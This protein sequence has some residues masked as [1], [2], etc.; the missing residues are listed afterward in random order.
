MIMSLRSFR[1]RLSRPRLPRTPQ[2]LTDS[3][4]LSQ[5]W[6]YTVELMPGL[7]AQ[8][9]YPDSFPL[10]PRSL[11]RNCDLRG[12]ECLDLGSMEGLMP[13]LMG[14]Q[15]ARRVVATDAVDHCHDKM[16]AVRHYYDADFSFEKVGLMYDLVRK[17]GGTGGTGFDLINCSGLLY[18]V[19]S[20]LMVLAG[21]RPLLRKNGLLI[22][23]TN[24]VADQSV[25]MHFNEGGRLQEETNTFWYLSI[26]ALDYLLRYL[27]LAPIDCVYLPHREI[28]SSVRYV[29]ALESGY[30]SIVCRARDDVLAAAGDEWMGK[31]ARESWEYTGLID[32][33]MEARQGTTQMAYAGTVSPSLWRND[34][35]ALDLARAVP[36]RV[37]RR[38]EQP[39]DAHILKLDDVS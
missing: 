37:V 34:V 12:A 2:E 17:L 8:G 31:S 16:A 14:R 28:D 21:V 30:C 25:A 26:R 4:L 36:E 7:T 38:A 13:V 1:A 33:G 20:P 10:L 35:D 22:V 27:K 29:N 15:G 11:M 19:F 3:G 6:Y 23:S 32:W 5:W 39:S 9:Q 24:V 18:H